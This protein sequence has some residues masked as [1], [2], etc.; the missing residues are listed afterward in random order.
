V[1]LLAAYR[2]TTYEARTDAGLIEI[3][4]GEH[5]PRLDALLEELAK[6]CWSY[7]TAWNPG[8]TPLGASENARRNLALRAKLEDGGFVVFE[9]CGRPDQPGWQPEESFLALGLDQA[10]AMTLG[11]K[12]GQHAIVRAAVGEVA[13]LVL[14]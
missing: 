11:T 3:R 13:E 2:A 4:I 10:G 9:G 8:S 7:I 12:Y 1:G 14:C 5:T 6:S